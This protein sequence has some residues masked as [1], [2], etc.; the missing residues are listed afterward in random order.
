MRELIRKELREHF[1]VAVLGFAVLVV[2]L[3][4]AYSRSAN[5]LERSGFGSGYISNESLQPL[6]ATD[7]LVQAAFFCCIFGALLG[8]LQIRAEKH[9]DLW[10][11]LI[12]RP[13]PRSTILQSKILGGLILYAA[14]AGLP[15]LGLVLIA[16]IPG[17]VAAPF[18][19]AMA[20][21]LLAIFLL[22]AAFYLAGLIT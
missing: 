10:A 19:W 11:F 18:E 9:P 17:K 3:A 8:W 4:L 7:L 6:L 5:L 21:P 22:G 12:H 1:K 16:R 20:L 2:V 14:G 13:V 15:A